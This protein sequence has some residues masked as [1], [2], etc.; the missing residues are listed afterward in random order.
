[1]CIGGKEGRIAIIDPYAKAMIE[2]VQGHSQEIQNL[3]FYDSQMQLISISVD[4][5]IKVWDI[6]R[7]ECLQRI[8]P[9]EW[10]INKGMMD[11]NLPVSASMFTRWNGGIYTIRGNCA[12]IWRGQTDPQ[13]ELKALQLRAFAK[14]GVSVNTDIDLAVVTRPFKRATE[15]DA[16]VIIGDMEG[17]KIERN[18]AYEQQVKKIYIDALSTRKIQQEASA[19][20]TANNVLISKTSSLLIVLFSETSRELVTI[21]S[22]NLVRVWKLA[23]GLSNLSYSLDLEKRITTGGL[24]AGGNR[25]VVC[26]EF[27]KIKVF[28]TNSGGTLFTL[29]HTAIE[30]HS[31]KFMP[32]PSEFWIMAC[33][34]HGKTLFWPNPEGLGVTT[35]SVDICTKCCIGH[36]KEVLCVSMSSPYLA[37]GGSDGFLTIWNSF[38]CTFKYTLTF[39]LTN[40]PAPSPNKQ[41][42]TSAVRNKKK[43]M[44]FFKNRSTISGSKRDILS[45]LGS[46]VHP[47]QSSNSICALQFLNTH[48]IHRPHHQ[49]LAVS[50]SVGVIH[51]VDVTKGEI[52]RPFLRE[53]GPSFTSP[54][55]AYDGQGKMLILGGTSGIAVLLD[56]GAPELEWEVVRD[57]WTA[58]LL[59]G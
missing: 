50:D 21:D 49:L 57:N 42:S 34:A 40:S 12:E 6:H 15:G 55:F 45:T 54:H 7:L 5:Y 20:T 23:T 30:L 27:G 16:Y 44:F 41:E 43:S 59:V 9:E 8:S 13:V 14:A 29:P 48:W 58:H 35:S 56:V 17:G 32:S 25:L 46:Q 26:N 4:K 11:K 37:T 22:D 2:G 51:L 31:I 39:P 10:P 18:Y 28:N 36:R 47:P 33:G 19:L 38:G 52:I 53:G 3:Y 1:M 24:N